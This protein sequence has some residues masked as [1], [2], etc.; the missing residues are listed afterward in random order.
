[1]ANI[2]NMVTVG[3]IEEHIQEILKEKRNLNTALVDRTE[4][5]R[6]HINSLIALYA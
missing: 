1:M 2:V 3:T 5:E 4:S 6:E